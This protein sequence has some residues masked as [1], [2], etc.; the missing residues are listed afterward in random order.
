M[1]KNINNIIKIGITFIIV[2][3]FF[4]QQIV[5]KSAS[6]KDVLEKLGCSDWYDF[7]IKYYNGGK[8]KTDLLKDLNSDEIKV[9]TD[10]CNDVI[11]ECN[12]NINQ[13]QFCQYQSR[14]QKY[15]GGIGNNAWE[16]IKNMASAVKENVGS[17]QT[18]VT[19]SDKYLI[20]LNDKAVHDWLRAN[21][22]AVDG[23]SKEVKENWLGRDGITEDDK[24]VIRGEKEMTSTQDAV[25]DADTSSDSGSDHIYQ[26]PSKNGTSSSASSLDDV[27]GDADSFINSGNNDKITASSLQSFSNTFYNILLTIG[28]VV[29]ALVGMVIGIR[30]MVGGAAERANIKELLIPYVV[31]CIIV[32]GAFAIWKIVVTI[33]QQV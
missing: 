9:I 30:F 25:Q 12:T 13:N 7:V 5:V 18:D 8:Y 14:V 11:K 15:I 19:D 17:F 32:F 4:S 20:G 27:M 26:L 33:M 21:N 23:L 1:R 31:G 28:I 29:A 22:G 16:V 24:A 6:S 3:C 2:I 10:K